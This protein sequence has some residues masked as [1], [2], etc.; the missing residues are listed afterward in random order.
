MSRLLILPALVL[1]LAACAGGD[2]NGPRVGVVI[3]PDGTWLK[4]TP[5]N[6]RRVHQQVV[7]GKLDERFGGSGAFAVT[8][9]RLPRWREAMDERDNGQWIYDEVAVTIACTGTTTLAVDAVAAGEVVQANLGRKQERQGRRIPVSLVQPA[10]PAAPVAVAETSPP[11]ALAVAEAAPPTAALRHY[12]VQ[13][14]DTLADISTVFYGT[15]QH[16]RRIVEANPGLDPAT[17]T[18]G[19]D[20]VIPPKPLAEVAPTP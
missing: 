13:P 3:A 18:A 11:P 10:A 5:E 16:W 9:D 19:T 17:L 2:A 8:I 7:A 6:L 4:Q 1:L 20:L 15:P 14:G 12:R